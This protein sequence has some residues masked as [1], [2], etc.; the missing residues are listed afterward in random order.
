MPSPRQAQKASSCLLPVT[1]AERLGQKQGETYC[2][3]SVTVTSPVKS[4]P[5]VRLENILQ[6]EAVLVRTAVL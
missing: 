5:F 3:P 1:M 2:I 4:P 6:L